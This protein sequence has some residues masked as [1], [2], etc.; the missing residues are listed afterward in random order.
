MKEKLT[1]ALNNHNGK[2]IFPF[3]W[4]H[5]EDDETLLRELHS[6]YDCGIRSVCVESR[7]HEGFGEESWYSDMDLIL[8]ECEKLGM[9][10][11]LLDDKHFPTGYANG[12]IKT[13]YPHLGKRALTAHVVDV[14]GPVTDGAVMCRKFMEPGSELIAVVACERVPGDENQSMTGRS[15]DLTDKVDWDGGMVFFDLPEGYW[16]VFI[17]FHKPCQDCYIDMLRQESVHVLIEAVY[18]PHYQRYQKYFGKTFRGYFSDEPYIMGDAKLPLGNESVMHG[19]FPWNENVRQELAAALPNWKLLLPYLWFPGEYASRIR[20]TFMDI[21]TKLYA[22]HFAWQLGDWCRARGVEYIGHVVEDVGQHTQFSSGGHFFRALDG[23]DMAGIDVVLCQIV[24]GMSNNDIAVPCWYKVADH[25]M[26]H[27]TLAKLGASHSHI[28]PQKK[29]RAMCEIYGAYGWAEGL[30]MMKWLTDHMLVRGINNFVPHAFTPKYPDPDCPPHFYNGGHNPEFAGFGKLMGYMERVAGILSDGRHHASAAILYHAQAEWSGEDYMKIDEPAKL[31]TNSQIDY[32]IVPEDYLDCA[33]VENRQ[34]K[35]NQETYRVFLMPYAKRLP[36]AV[37]EK[38]YDFALKGL[39]VWCIDG[40]PEATCEGDLIPAD[41]LAQFRVIAL[42]KLPIAMRYQGF[43]DV[44][45]LGENT[46]HLRVYHYSR[47]GGHALMLTNE[48]IYGD[49]KAKLSVRDFSGGE[50]VRYDAM[51]NQAVRDCAE[52]EIELCIPPYGSE[53]IFF[54]DIETKNIPEKTEKVWKKLP[55]EELSWRVS[56]AGVDD[57]QPGEECPAAFGEEEQ[58]AKLYNI[59]RKKKQF[60]GF[61]RYETELTIPGTGSEEETFRL[62][63]G[64]VGEV[65]EVWLDGKKLGQRII[66]PY[67]FEFAAKPGAQLKL[68]V[69]TT[70]HLGFAQQDGFSAYLGFDPVGLLGP[71]ALEG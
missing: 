16:R 17:I 4:Q 48:G 22:K 40:K 19:S 36:R 10:F 38:L 32:D 53:L 26:F 67:R 9:E 54:G 55:L 20:V 8:A 25:K 66:P 69:V 12:Y 11:W 52:K 35:L 61:V 28:Q 18:E 2:H 57:Y 64:R 15:L 47:G 60:A 21:V 44:T 7:P 24:P 46:E 45:A 51:E 42:E 62:D 37:V 27:Y 63:L 70:S 6:I 3:F 39:P 31:L 5:G 30:P 56:F 71:V 59:V 34:L 43:E 68:C 13:K 41:M 23:Q 29:G 50:F 1:Q 49:V 65:A 14:T 33:A 58:V